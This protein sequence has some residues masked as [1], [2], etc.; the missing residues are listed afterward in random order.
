MKLN[1]REVLFGAAAVAAAPVLPALPVEALVPL[2]L[3]TASTWGMTA[4][5]ATDVGNWI[6]YYYLTNPHFNEVM[7]AITMD[8]SKEPVEK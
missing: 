4:A 2:P 8:V 5:Y 7:R 3:P 1:R 6:R